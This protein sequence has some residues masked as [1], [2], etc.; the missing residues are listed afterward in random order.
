M[1]KAACLA[2]I[3]CWAFRSDMVFSF[4]S[5][6]IEYSSSPKAQMRTIKNKTLGNIFIL[7]RVDGS[8]CQLRC[9]I[10]K[11]AAALKITGVLGEFF[12][13]KIGDQIIWP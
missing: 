4:T 10:Q 5:S 11:P 12:G 8:H 3:I 13:E 1:P 9:N 6:Y 7:Y 2:R